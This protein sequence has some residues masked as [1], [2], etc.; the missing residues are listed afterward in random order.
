[1]KNFNSTSIRSVTLLMVLYMNITAFAQSGPGGIGKTDGTSHL[2]L[3]LKAD[4]GVFSDAGTTAAT[5]GQTVQQ[6]NDQS[7]NN[8]HATQAVAASRP[9]FATPVFNR[10]PALT[11][12]SGAKFLNAALNISPSVNPVV[13]I[14]SV[15]AY[16]AFTSPA[17]F[18]KIWGHDDGQYD[19]TVG[20]D[21]RAN[22]SFSYFTGTAVADFPFVTGLPLP[23]EPFITTAGYTPTT[24]IGFQ[25]GV[26]GA[27]GTVSNND[28][29][30]EFTIGAINSQGVEP[31][32]GNIIEM[33]VYDTVLSPSQRINIENY[34]SAKYSTS[35]VGNDIYTM[36]NPANGNFDYD[37]I[38]VNHNLNDPNFVTSAR[39]SG[40]LTLS[41]ASNL[42]SGGSYLVGHDNGTLTPVTTDLPAGVAN[43]LTRIW[44]GTENNGD[45]GT[46]DLAFDLPAITNNVSDLRLLVDRNN[47]GTFADETNGNGV[48]S[49]FTK[50]GS[51]YTINVNMGDGQRFTIGAVTPITLPVSL[52]NILVEQDG[53]FNKVQWKTEKEFSFDHFEVQRSADGI[54]FT[55]LGSVQAA[56]ND[57]NALKNYSFVDNQPLSASYYRLKI[58]DQGGQFTYSSIVK[59][60][61][62]SKRFT[63][64]P[65]PSTN[66]VTITGLDGSSS[67]IE[68]LDINGKTLEQKT[69]L[70][71]QY[72]LYLARYPQGTYYI[73]IKTGND[74]FTKSI[75]KQ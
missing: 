72:S 29:R 1:M 57:A 19:R 32:M 36:D 42:F 69:T 50:S 65:N 5:N 75:I 52:R 70:N 47:N 49:G 48:I 30:P 23:D 8:F 63:I 68:L 15:S 18:S 12:A 35:V 41:N 28:G 33:I 21:P 31:W 64:S 55:T 45:I 37:V 58:V 71:T 56:T 34:L 62:S 26:Q 16:T 20:F 43:R 59:V 14:I 22:S 53:L 54:N 17:P 44:A 11:F 13:T 24:F 27:N 66:M 6:W 73:K 61:K 51:T 4:K 67:S 25:Q 10:L 3:W 40:V 60:I 9:V 39:G 2:K 74:T 38:G 46:L 7:G